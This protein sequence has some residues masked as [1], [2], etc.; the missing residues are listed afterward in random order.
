MKIAA[1][2]LVRDSERFIIPHLKMYKG[3]NRNIVL[4][5]PQEMSGG[6][7]GH[8]K[9]R[10][11]SRE[12]ITKYCP[13]VEIYETQNSQW[14]AELFNEAIA[15]ASDCD[16]V[17]IFHADV[18]MAPKMWQKVKK[19]LETTDFDVYK[20]D[21]TKC[22]INY[23]RDFEHG[24][25]DC[26]DIEPIAVKSTT[27]FHTFYSFEGTSYTIEDILVH[28][29]TGWKGTF[30]DKNGLDI[31]APDTVWLPCPPEIRELFNES[32]Y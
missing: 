31:F 4:F 9:E 12:L 5:I 29:F 17:V 16:K 21:M 22:T 32:R 26:L 27:R 14:N 10:D 7:T 30:M 2:T 6:S 20:L 3:V 23:Y 24:L 18:V 19:L 1:V 13:E 28:H 8:S 15:L 25:R 11:S